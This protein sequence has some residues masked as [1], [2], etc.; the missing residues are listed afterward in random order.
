[1]RHGRHAKKSEKLCWFIPKPILDLNVARQHELVR[2]LNGFVFWLKDTRKKSDFFV[3]WIVSRF[4][5]VRS[6]F[7]LDSSFFRVCDSA[8]QAGVNHSGMSKVHEVLNQ[9]IQVKIQD[10]RNSNEFPVS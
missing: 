5:E 3:R 10:A 7:D 8:N 4:D 1:M 9:V 6:R 2:V